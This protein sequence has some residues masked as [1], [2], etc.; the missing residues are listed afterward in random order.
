MYHAQ[1][2][3]KPLALLAL[4]CLLAGLFP[5]TALAGTEGLV[6]G[7]KMRARAALK[8][9]KKAG[10]LQPGKSDKLTA[11]QIRGAYA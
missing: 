7:Q 5:A 9:V 6:L 10:C 1:K 4:F 2:P 3:I 8:D 11:V